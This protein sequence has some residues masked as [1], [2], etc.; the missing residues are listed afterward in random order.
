VDTILIVDS[1]YRD[2][3]PETVLDALFS[4]LRDL[5]EGLSDKGE[6]TI[7][8]HQ[9]RS[10]NVH[11]EKRDFD[12]DIVPAVA[13]NGTDKP[14]EVP[15]KDWGKWVPTH[16]LGYAKA[17]SK[18]NADHQEKVVP[19]VKM[20]KHWRDVHMI[21]RRPKSYWLECLVHNKI[22]NENVMTDGA[23]YAESFRD[24][25]ASI[26]DG[27]Q[28]HLEKDGAVPEIKDP[29]LGN[30][31]AHNWQRDNF[32]VFMSRVHE[33]RRWAERALAQDD[34]SKAIELWQKIFGGEWFPTVVAQK[35]GESLRAATLAGNIFVT[36]NG[37]VH[38]EKPLERHVQAPPT[39][40]YGKD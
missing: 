4:A 19:L 36:P 16:P 8:R 38:T 40:F 18:L 1:A 26:E 32:E 9:R 39:K 30:N 20:L 3:E 12:L 6:V 35:M 27:F 33:S 22:K 14:L 29:M 17:L 24:L 15:D 13:L 25:M 23:S 7:R 31:V 21:Y 34:D 28:S 2:E 11:L 5:P 37:K 10:V